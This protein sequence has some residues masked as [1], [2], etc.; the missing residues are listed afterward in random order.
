M[1]TN[2]NANHAN[3]AN[4]NP[5][6]LDALVDAAV[7]DLD[8]LE[9][10][11]KLDF[12]IPPTE[13]SQT[14]VTN[15]V[16]L[17]AL[18]LAAS[19]ASSDPARF[20]EYQSLPDAAAFV[21]TMARLADRANELATHV[22]KAILKQRYP[23]SILVLSLYQVVKGL[24]RVA[25]NEVM[26][27]NVPKLAKELAPKRKKPAQ[28]AEQA[29]LKAAAKKRARRVA[30]AKAV[31]A[32]NE[33]PIPVGPPAGGTAPAAEAQSASTQPAAAAA[34]TAAPAASGAVPPTA[35]TLTLTPAAR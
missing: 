27:E 16:S 10:K 21:E 7:Q 29:A 28:T 23:A 24:A 5:N 6:P 12:A 32:A 3:A 34:E 4:P 33:A 13:K 11:L 25:D 9:T 30:K 31:I 17:T 19:I 18:G 1:N 35:V 14:K 26:R 8:A 22:G 15:K 2:A 20:P